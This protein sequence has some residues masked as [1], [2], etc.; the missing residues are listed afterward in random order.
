MD[1]SEMAAR[2]EDF[3]DREDAE[4][5]SEGTPALLDKYTYY[6]D[7]LA[8]LFKEDDGAEDDRELIDPTSLSEAYGAIKEA[9]DAFDFNTADEL[10]GMLKGY[11]LPKDEEARY[12]R[13]CG[14]ITRLERDAILEELNNG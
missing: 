11:R 9:V 7:R 10:V 4:A 3:G 12:E 8:S 13:I 1:L 14:M 5:I 2:L 6:A